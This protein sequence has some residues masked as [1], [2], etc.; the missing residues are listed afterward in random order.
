MRS[1]PAFLNLQPASCASLTIMAAVVPQVFSQDRLMLA[2]AASGGLSRPMAAFLLPQMLRMTR[3]EEVLRLQL[4]SAGDMDNSI[5]HAR[6]E[7]AWAW[8]DVSKVNGVRA[9]MSA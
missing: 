8:M 1:P 5:Q 6:Q 3:R 7:E 9:G 4:W 2:T